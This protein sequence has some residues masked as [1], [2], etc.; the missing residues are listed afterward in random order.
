ML[1]L[2]SGAQQDSRYRHRLEIGSPQANPG[3][4]RAEST[5]WADVHLE[6]AG[7]I[8]M[9]NDAPAKGSK[10]FYARASD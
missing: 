9:T 3:L 2:R 6:E 5:S 4:G 8:A 10:S 1:E 7:V